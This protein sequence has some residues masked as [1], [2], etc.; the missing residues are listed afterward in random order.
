M[1]SLPDSKYIIQT[2][3]YYFVE[4]HDVDPS[5]GYISVSAKGIINGLS[6][7]PN[8][9]A[10]FGPDS[11]NPNYSGSGIPYTQTSGIQEAG[12]YGTEIILR[13][14]I[15]EIN[16]PI[17]FTHS[18]H[19]IG[20]GKWSPFGNSSISD[21][22]DD[23]TVL[24]AMSSFS[25][26]YLIQMYNS[27]IY[28]ENVT[29]DLNGMSIKGIY[30]YSSSSYPLPSQQ[31][32][33][34]LNNVYGINSV[35]GY[36]Y[37]TETNTWN[38]IFERCIF[39]GSGSSIQITNSGS[40]VWVLN[41]QD[42]TSGGMYLDGIFNYIFGGIQQLVQIGGS[43]FFE[44]CNWT[45]N[46]TDTD[47]SIL[48]GMT[49]LSISNSVIYLQSAY[50][51]N[52][53]SYSVNNLSLFNNEFIDEYNYNPSVIFSSLTAYGRFNIAG[54]LLVL[55]A[56]TTLPTLNGNP[57]SLRQMLDGYHY[58]LDYAPPIT[59]SVPASG[60]AQENTN[61][62]AVDVY[63]YGGDVTEIQITRNGT[64]YTVLSVST[65][66]AMSGQVYKLNPGDSITV[67]YSTAPTWKWVVV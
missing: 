50:V 63:V 33:N 48:R 37:F 32:Y 29:L 44:Q 12:N 6:S 36:Y 39:T 7:I 51:I 26:G 38:N 11:Y 9:G 42:Y 46:F 10:D 31:L 24:R 8:D 57:F 19:I 64:A 34:V 23:I 1:G 65:A 47:I 4:S 40:D 35:S 25:A 55:N 30:A 53:N 3:G 15:Y 27:A 13:S 5:K 49:T 43:A 58:A 66:I 18:V 59:P 61:P 21:I 45:N 52:F 62:Y 14:G 60:T 41:T 56:T 2:D 20:S 28:I 17:Q 54:N 67:T 16:A 22:P